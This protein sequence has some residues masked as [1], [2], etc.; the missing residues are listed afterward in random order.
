MKA[1]SSYRCV[2]EG[3]DT[4]PRNAGGVSSIALPAADQRRRCESAGV[5]TAT[6]DES[7]IRLPL[8]A[9]TTNLA[10]AFGVRLMIWTAVVCAL[11]VP[12]STRWL[13]PLIQKIRYPWA[14]DTGLHEISAVVV[15]N[16]VT[17]TFVGAPTGLDVVELAPVNCWTTRLATGVNSRNRR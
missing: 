12:S 10:V 5:V 1:V 14:P 8:N 17:V 9:S 3:L 15:D 2:S 16:A 13:L 7:A 11:T 6:T 4:L